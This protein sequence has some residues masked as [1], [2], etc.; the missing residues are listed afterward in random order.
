MTDILLQAQALMNELV[1]NRRKIHRHPETGFDTVKTQQLVLKYLQ[2]EGLE[3]VPSEVGVVAR[4]TT[5]CAYSTVLMRADMDA[6]P[7][8]EESNAPYASEIPGKMHACGH[9][10]H[11]AMLLS[12]AKLINL[13]RED[14]H[15][16]VLFIFQPAEEGPGKG[17][18]TV[19]VENL[20]KAGLLQDVKAAFALHVSTEF[21]Y[22]K[23]GIIYDTYSASVDDFKITL[24]GKSSHAANPSAGIDAISGAA[25]FITEME[26]YMSRRVDC[27]DPAVFSITRISGGTV[28][29]VLAETVTLE[30]TIRCQSQ[31]HREQLPKAASQIL[32]G[33]TLSTGIIYEFELIEGVPPLVNNNKMV[34]YAKKCAEQIVGY[35]NVIQKRT[36]TNSAEDF[37]YFTQAVPGACI[38][39]GVRNESEGFVHFMH[40]PKF[41]L[42]ERA[43]TIGCALLCQL[44]FKLK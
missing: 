9:D 20:R 30:G 32:D 7:M 29:N 6:L 24:H 11:T 2:K 37:A 38:Y 28:T 5:P 22:G 40:N 1:S 3:I 4:I 25:R 16:N 15:A 13:N 44:A 26:S 42:D 21:E 35:D 17:G 39:L 33:L 36:P 10:A 27:L 43:L 18:A 31:A 14:L 12:A 23:I 19:M 34:D 41:N 8:Q